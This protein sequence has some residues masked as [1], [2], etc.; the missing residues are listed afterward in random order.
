ME[1]T[2][3]ERIIF[4]IDVN[5]AFLSWSAVRRLSEDPTCLDLRSV[6]S[7]VGGNTEN[8]HGIILAKSIPAKKFGVVTAE[9]VASALK[10]CPELIIVPPEGE[11]YHKCSDAFMKILRNNCPIV[12]SISIDEAFMDMSGMGSIF[13]SPLQAAHAIKDEIKNSLGFTVNV[14]ISSN[15][16]LA[17]MA[18]DFTK[19][20]R[21]H[22][23][24]PE[25]I[26]EKMWDL[27]LKE[28]YGI[29]KSTEAALLSLGFKTI[30]DAAAA[31]EEYLKRRLG[32]KSGKWLHKAANGIDEGK[33][34][35]DEAPPKGYGNSVTL[36]EDLTEQNSSLV[37]EKTLLSLSDSVASRMR[38]DSFL[39]LTVGVK[40]KT[41]DFVTRSRQRT[42]N[43]P[44]SSTDEIFKTAVE[45]FGELWDRRTPVRLV[46][47]FASSLTNEETFQL[48]MLEGESAFKQREALSKIDA[49]TD[50]IRERFGKDSILRGSMID[51]F[52][53]KD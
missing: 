32:E 37:L 27:P 18:G 44:T 42:L 51:P 34:Q 8:R 53:K 22:T 4:H 13:S 41:K 40:L 36:P 10:K 30:G 9:T 43:K 24:F 35:T 5:S 29:G 12:Q 45:L 21:V 33:V 17:K 15:K 28:L 26:K 49:A 6:P 14:G 16:L 48:N 38:R 2:F 46:G 19:P 20:D 23:L 25:E 11:T 50:E 52:V 31:D 7:A 47:V 3:S 39:A 1:H